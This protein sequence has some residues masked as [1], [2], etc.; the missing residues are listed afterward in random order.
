M[1]HPNPYQSPA[2]VEPDENRPPRKPD[3]LS[4]YGWPV[5]FAANMIVPLLIGLDVTREG[6]LT[7]L[8][9]ACALLLVAGWVFYYLRPQS[10]RTVLLGAAMLAVTQ[11]FP[12]LQI[13]AGLGALLVVETIGLPVSPQSWSPSPPPVVLDLS[14]FWITCQT[15]ITLILLA[16]A[17]GAF[18]GIF[19]P[20]HWLD[21]AERPRTA[22]AADEL[23]CL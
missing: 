20:R 4:I 9:I 2:A 5:V 16:I 15:A 10:M 14:I 12:I 23:P 3:W 22:T 6:G 17:L 13:V 11:I 18:A 8:V 7:G 19:L 1:N 21:P